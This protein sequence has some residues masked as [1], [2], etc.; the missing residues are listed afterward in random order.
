MLEVQHKINPALLH[1]AINQKRA[2][3]DMVMKS[4]DSSGSGAL[5]DGEPCSCRG[6]DDDDDEVLR[7]EYVRSYK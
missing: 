6:D 1:T 7:M 4:G 2:L 3:M 5:R